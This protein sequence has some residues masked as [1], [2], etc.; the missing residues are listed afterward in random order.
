VVLSL[1]KAVELSDPY[2]RGHS[3]RVAEYAVSIGKALGLEDEELE[4]SGL[5]GEAIPLGSRIIAVADAFDALTTDRPYRSKLST[6]DAKR[7]L[8]EGAGIQWDPE[9]V[10][11]ALKVLKPK[12]EFYENPML[13]ELDQIRYRSTITFYRLPVLYSIISKFWEG[14]SLEEILDTTLWELLRSLRLEKGLIQLVE[15]G[16]LKVKASF[17]FTSQNLEKLNSLS[18][19]D[20][21]GILGIGINNMGIPAEY[22]EFSRFADATDLKNLRVIVSVPIRSSKGEPIYGYISIMSARDRKFTEEERKFLEAVADH[23]ALIIEN[24]SYQE[25]KRYTS[26]DIV[27]TLIR[28]M[29][30]KGIT[31]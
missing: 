29:E 12:K 9:I 25:L 17:G 22:R 2:T 7:V 6:R 16:E 20:M 15:K 10:K 19:A 4:P 28:A 21:E 31:S 3:E 23:L 14:M 13:A 8:R 24:K 1:S 18:I 30:I 27:K 5:K 26:Y 11:V